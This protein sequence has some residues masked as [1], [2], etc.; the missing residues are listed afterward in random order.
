MNRY[1]AITQIRKK[2]KSGKV[3]IGSWMQIPHGSVAEIMGNAGYEWVSVDLEHGSIST[4]QLPDLFRAI[5]TCGTLPLVRLSHAHPKYCKHSLDAGAGGVIVPMVESSD[6]LETIIEHCSWPPTGQR[7]VGYSRANLFGKHF[8]EYKDEAQSPIVVAQIEHIRAV[9]AL[10]DILKIQGLD[11]ILIGP[12]DLS[13]SMGLTGQFKAQEYN[14]VLSKIK[15][16]SQKFNIPYGIHVVQPDPNELK[17][18]ISEGFQFIAYSIDS[19]FLYRGVECP[20]F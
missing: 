13:A 1:K 15:M 7:G 14:D 11:A 10:E 20:R 5:E 2:L 18:K 4:H 12:Y 8:E 9:D 3:S 19:V 16:L 17:A 6:Q